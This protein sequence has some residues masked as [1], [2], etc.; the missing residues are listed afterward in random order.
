[1]PQ[2]SAK[3][4]YAP[5]EIG[6]TEKEMGQPGTVEMVAPADLP[7]FYELTVDFEGEAMVV[8]IVSIL[9]MSLVVCRCFALCAHSS[10]FCCSCLVPQ[11]KGGV[12]KR[13]KF[14]ASVIVRGDSSTTALPKGE[15]RDDLFDCF[16]HGICHPHLCL[17]VCCFECA[18]GQLL[19]RMKLNV[20]GLPATPHS[21]SP[22]RIYWV[23]GA[24]LVAL[25]FIL[26]FVQGFYDNP[27]NPATAPEWVPAAKMAG[28]IFIYAIGF[29]MIL[30]T[31]RVRRY[32][33]Q[34]YE[35]RDGSSDDCFT[36]VCCRCCAVAQMLRHTADYENQSA[37]FCSETGLPDHV[38]HIV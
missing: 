7:S 33:R 24:S 13:E 31:F 34:K 26:G 6:V 9:D 17:T 11:P 14:T 19:T 21:W 25:G 4:G 10:R 20:F 38:D 8:T 2:D 37:N 5:L 18:L 28:N 12:K 30:V 1:M 29:A 16:K 22:F 35:I 23:V 3:R 36:I 15:W 27:E 32:I